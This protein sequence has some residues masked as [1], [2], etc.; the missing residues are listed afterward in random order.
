MTKGN[1]K[2]ILNGIT[3]RYGRRKALD[4]L[5]LEIEKGSI[6]G[7]VGSNGAGKTTTM[8]ILAGITGRDKGT[9]SVFGNKKFNPSSSP[10]ILTLL[11]QDSQLPI[12]ARVRQQLMFY[13]E[14]QGLKGKDLMEEVDRVI[15][16]VHLSD[17]ANSKMKSLSHGMKRRFMVAQAFLGSP[18]IILLDEPLSGLDPKEV[19]NI[20]DIIRTRRGNQTIVVSSHNLHEIE[21]MCDHVAFMEKGKRTRQD[22]IRSIT[23]RHDRIR[24]FLADQNPAVDDLRGKFPGPELRIERENLPDGVG[25]ILVCAYDCEKFTIRQINA[26]ILSFL[27]ASN[28]GIISV[29]HGDELETVYMNSVRN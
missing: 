23:G 11:P 27:L 13:G 17:R 18:K 9:V 29:E 26:K 7:L 5:D 24:Y 12:Y 8:S 21:R 6:F 15:E 28:I 1:N 10:G 4:G 20:R 2:I 3:K 25:S 14:L 16:W 19:V 22:T